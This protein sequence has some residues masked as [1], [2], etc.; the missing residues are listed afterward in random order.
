VST[1]GKVGSWIKDNAGTGAAL[2]GSLLTGNVPGAIAAGVSLVS[3]ATGTDDPDIALQQLQ[4][5]PDAIIRL[6]ELAAQEEQSIRRHIEEMHRLNLEDKQK[7]HST[8][9]ATIQAGDRA[10]DRFVRWT[11]PGQSWV[12]LAAAIAYVFYDDSPDLMILGALLTLP[13]AYAGLRQVGKGIDS[14]VKRNKIA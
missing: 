10:D 13:W 11:R 7:S 9:Q 8:A 2:V 3:G 6:K 5:N 12:C 4:G 14:V 1:W